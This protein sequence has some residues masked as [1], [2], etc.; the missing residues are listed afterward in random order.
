MNWIKKFRADS[1]GAV[2]VD[3][4]VICAAVA[5]LAASGALFMQ[6]ELQVFILD[7]FSD[8]FGIG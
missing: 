7:Y 2:T 1:D 3:W 6:D 5:A 4:V 8:L